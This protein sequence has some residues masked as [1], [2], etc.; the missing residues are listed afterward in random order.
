MVNHNVDSTNSI[1]DFE[2]IENPSKSIFD[3]RQVIGI[4]IISCFFFMI[5]IEQIINIIRKLQKNNG[6]DPSVIRNDPI[7]NEDKKGIPD[8]AIVTVLGI[9]FHCIADGFAF[10]ASGYGNLQMN[11]S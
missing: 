3:A 2:Y 1:T 4:C 5:I 10:G 9:I 11:N 6:R 8:E 7:F